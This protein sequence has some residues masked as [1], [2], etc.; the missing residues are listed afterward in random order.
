MLQHGA[1]FKFYILY[2]FIILYTTIVLHHINI[3]VYIKSIKYTVN[4]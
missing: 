1:N 2:I 4:I 3:S